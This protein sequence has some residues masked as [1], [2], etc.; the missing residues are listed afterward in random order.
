[1]AIAARS[2]SWISPTDRT[3]PAVWLGIIWLG[4]I[5]GFGADLPSFLYKRP[6]AAGILYVHAAVFVG[7]LV[8]VTVQVVFVLRGRLR[9][10]RR[11]GSVAAYIALLMVPF[12]FATG[13]TAVAQGRLP[14]ALLTLNLVDLLGFIAFIAIGLRYRN[15]PAAHKRLM[16][17]AMVSIADPGFARFSLHLLPHPHTPL[18]SFMNVFYGNVLLLAAMFG[19]DLWRQGRIH[20]ALLAGGLSLAGAELLTAYLFYDTAWTATAMSL[21]RVWGHAVGL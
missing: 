20:P 8:L 13:L 19:W 1:M 17:L 5:V 15:H 4:M 9:Q 21:A 16:M 2:A 14:P 6:P 10:H 18:G 3:A 7:W 11:L 12:G